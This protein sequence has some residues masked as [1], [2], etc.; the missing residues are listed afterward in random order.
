MFKIIGRLLGFAPE[1][2]KYDKEILSFM[3]IGTIIFLFL[4]IIHTEKG[5][6]FLY[7]NRLTVSIMSA[8]E[9]EGITNEAVDKFTYSFKEYIPINAREF[10]LYDIK[11]RLQNYI[12]DLKNENNS[13]FDNIIDTLENIYKIDDKEKLLKELN[14]INIKD[15]LTNISKEEIVK[16][17]LEETVEWQTSIFLSNFYFALGTFLGFST[18]VVKVICEIELVEK[19][20]KNLKKKEQIYK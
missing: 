10:E 8:A 16:K 19:K 7:T 13:S 6:K 18:I 17:D 12:N 5:A 4:G 1:E 2:I 14:D 11:D 20:N 15:M 9:K 3:L